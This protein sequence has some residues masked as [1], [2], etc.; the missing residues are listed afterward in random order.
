MVDFN[1]TDSS[2]P[3][4]L[5][6]VLRP[7]LD[8]PSTLIADESRSASRF[9]ALLSVDVA[10]STAAAATLDLSELDVSV[11]GSRVTD[12]RLSGQINLG[13]FI[14]GS[15]PLVVD[16]PETLTIRTFGTNDERTQ[17]NL[18]AFDE[19]IAGLRAVSSQAATFDS[20]TSTVEVSLTPDFTVD[21]GVLGQFNQTVDVGD[22]ISSV[23]TLAGET[24]QSTLE[25][26]Y[27]YGVVDNNGLVADDVT[28]YAI[29]GF[30]TTNVRAPRLTSVGN[31]DSDSAL[32]RREFS[33]STHTNVR[34]NSGFD[35]LL[36]GTESQE[37]TL[38]AE[39]GVRG[40]GLEG[41]N[42][43]AE[44]TFNIHTV[45][46]LP[47]QLSLNQT[48]NVVE[49]QNEQAEGLDSASAYLRG[50]ERDGSSR[51]FLSGAPSSLDGGGSA[52]ITPTFDDTD[53]PESELGR[54]YRTEFTLSFEDGVNQFR[55]PN[56]GTRAANGRRTSGRDFVLNTDVLGSEETRQDLSWVVERNVI[57]SNTSGT[58]TLAAGT[59]LRDEGLNLTNTDENT[60][61][62]VPT[63]FRVLD[64]ELLSDE[65]TVSVNFVN[66]DDA[67]TNE[68]YE[69]TDTSIL[70]S[71]IVELEGLDEILHVV[72]LSFDAD[73]RIGEVL[74][75]DPNG[76]WVNAVL[77]NSD[78]DQEAEPDPTLTE[79]DFISV[80]GESVL[81]SE[82]L[83]ERR[84]FGDYDT[85]LA[86]LGEGEGPVL[87]A[88]GSDSQ[89]AWA[90][91]DHNSSFAAA[92]GVPEPGSGLLL[93]GLGVLAA[94]T[95]RR[96]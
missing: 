43:L 14:A 21:T 51:W 75:L 71:D 88:F 17:L 11:Q 49:I 6:E 77:G 19:Q 87:G 63:E 89:H 36:D 73:G 55:L 96:R 81:I 64:S 35:I 92:V 67:A 86:S 74:W 93:V 90:V 47:S 70:I 8:P 94:A 10:D 72:E 62:E 79:G 9:N 34:L 28:V 61:L 5:L 91:I 69:N 37:V 80:D 57:V 53:L 60:S 7:L 54:D 78:I 18:A 82:Y 2:Q 29:D 39:N 66:L 22:F 32:I 27:R 12:R 30:D 48:G 52:T 3:A 58:L 41:E 31:F 59:S 25:I 33:T 65:A 26:G 16:Q 95:R 50:A 20:A 15:E 40:E 4:P 56:E 76:D 85:Y 84:F 38:N 23:E 45:S 24:P 42:V 13:R 46:I 68:Q 83:D 1:R 44:A